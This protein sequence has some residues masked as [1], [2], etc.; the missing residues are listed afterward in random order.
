MS[1]RALPLLSFNENSTP[2]PEDLRHVNVNVFNPEAALSRIKNAMEN[3]EGFAMA[4]LNLDHVV[5]LSYDNVFLEAYHKHDIVVPDGF[6]IVWLGRI[7]GR[8]DIVRTT[9][10]DIVLPVIALMEKEGKSLAL[11]GTTQDVLDDVRKKIAL[12]YPNLKIVYAYAPPYKFDPDSDEAGQILKDIESSGA[13]ICFLAFGAPKQEVLAARGVSRKS[14]VGYI[15]V[16]A[17]LDFIAGRQMR[18]PKWIQKCNLEW[19][20]RLVH[21][22]KRLL[23]RY[24]Q[25]ALIF[26]ALLA[27][28]VT[29]TK[30][31]SGDKDAILVVDYSHVHRPTTGIERVSLDLFSSESLKGIKTHHI[32]AKST[33]GM[34]KAQWLSLPLWALCHRKDY[35]L[36]SGFPASLLLSLF[37]GRRVISYIHDLFL[38]ERVA[39]LNTTAKYYMRPSFLYAVRHGKIFLVNSQ[40]T[41]TQLQKYCR[42]D[43]TIHM[44]RPEVPDTFNLAQLERQEKVE[45]DPLR[46]VTIGTVEPRKNLRYAASVRQTLARL[47][48]KKVELHSVGRTGW[49]DD[50]QWLARQEDVFLHGYCSP[51]QVRDIIRNADI[52]LSTSREEGLG[53]PLLEVQHGGIFVAASDIPVYREV[54]NDSGCLIPLD[55]EELAAQKLAEHYQTRNPR[56]TEALARANVTAWNK[57]AASDRARFLMWM[58][59]R[60]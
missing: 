50:A 48:G 36:C 35:F 9:G 40:Y 49:G 15:S 60:E 30:R 37:G 43:A 34:I 42:V 54:L 6:P 4:T 10:A 29:H 55:N 3:G 25:C 41:R 13:S 27:Q 19:V 45:G 8:R 26:P 53:L 38:I 12:I 18:A 7:A 32:R 52:F 20:W 28:T 5:K 1:Q 11:L 57:N 46:L 16:G 14:Q 56:E 59:E 47:L 2:P 44:L 51:E 22:P 58:V 17:A 33:L 24:T 39:D 31:K 23:K 21:N